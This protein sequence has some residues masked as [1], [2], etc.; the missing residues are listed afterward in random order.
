MDTR[1]S[2]SVC[3]VTRDAEHNI[4]RALRS[5]APLGAEVL[6]ADTGSR[7]RT[8][9]RARSLGAHVFPVTWRDDFA[10]AQNAAI[11]RATGDWV[12]WLNPDEQLVGAAGKTLVPLLARREA[13]AFLVRLQEVPAP[14]REPGPVETLLPRL[15]RRRADLRYVGRVHPHFET[16]LEDIARREGLEVYQSGLVVRRHGYTSVL[17]RDK[18]RWATRMLELEL[19]DRPGQLHYLIEYGRNLLRL[20]DPRG[21]AVLAQAAEIAEAH[22]GSPAAP[23][24]TVG[25]LL[26]YLLTV[27]PEQSK[28]SVSPERAAELARRWF[29]DTPPV[30]WA[31]AERAYR[32]GAVAE[33][34]A[35]LERLVH[36]G[37]S[38]TYDHSAAFDPAIVG[39][40][41]VLNLANCYLRLADPDRAEMWFASLFNDPAFRDQA[42]RGYA[43]AQSLRSRGGS[44]S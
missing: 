30:L 35:L 14:D 24:P 28:S 7:D 16:P 41:A 2:L 21:H 31:L 34:A 23:S 19:R 33:A 32:T 17:T 12:L 10:G 20:N 44:S 29:P 5:V 15:Y 11:E 25:S 9:E 26:E 42:R 13:I 43:T 40:P 4:E 22:A 39:A 6:V 18:L 1:T 38:G 27:S 36:L 3:L 37:R 8:V